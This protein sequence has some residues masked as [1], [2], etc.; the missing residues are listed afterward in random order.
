[1]EGDAADAVANGPDVEGPVDVARLDRAA[2]ASSEHQRVPL[3]ADARVWPVG[4]AGLVLVA[5]GDPQRVV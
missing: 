3:A 4:S 2:G 5:L 1:V